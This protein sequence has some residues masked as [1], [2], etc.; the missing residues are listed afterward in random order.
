MIMINYSF[1][2]N[3]FSGVFW[4]HNGVLEQRIIDE[5][6][7][8]ILLNKD[9]KV[10]HSSS[11]NVI[12]LNVVRDNSKISFGLVDNNCCDF[13]L[14][15]RDARPNLQNPSD[16]LKPWGDS[17]ATTGRNFPTMAYQSLEN[18][19]RDLKSIRNQN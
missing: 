10:Y 12:D 2:P 9:K 18:V 1:I 4:I 5:C 13:C 15:Q 8:E 14:A 16:K 17:C 19:T 11:N 3:S 7:E 6:I